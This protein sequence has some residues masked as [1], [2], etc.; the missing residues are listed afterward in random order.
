MKILS[1]LALALCFG[2]IFITFPSCKSETKTITKTEYVTVSDT[3]YIPENA[4]AT[5]FILV[6]HAE[7]AAVGAN[8]DLTIEGQERAKKL[9]N[10]LSKVKLDS[11]YSTNYKRT[12]QTA[13][14]TLTNQGLQISNYDGF[15]HEQLIDRILK[16]VNPGKV[17]IVGHSNTTAN[18]LNALT[19]TSDYP[20]LS[21]NA[22]DNLYIVSA[23]AKGNAE[24]LHL[25]Y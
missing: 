18:F 13:M 8:P 12:L 6:R 17:L 4:N 22:Y 24:V 23:K 21:E 20:D 5:T 10:I 19:A 14:P 15:D 9:A 16:N 25:K 3:L 11:V 7:K 2:A 1:Y